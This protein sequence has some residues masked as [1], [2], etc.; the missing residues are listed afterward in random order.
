MTSARPH[1]PYALPLRPLRRAAAALWLAALAGLA[2]QPAWAE[3]PLV[4]LTPVEAVDGVLERV[5]FGRVVAKETVDLAFQVGGQILT[6]PVTE[7]GFA[8]AGALIAELDLEPF[9]LAL[10]EAKASKDQIDRR[11]A[12]LERLQGST[13]SQVTVDDAQ[14]EAELAAIAVRNAERSLGL[15]TLRAPFD[16]LVSS[17]MV[18]NFSTTEAGAPVVRLHDMSDLRIEIDVPEVLF[19]RAGR[20]PNVELFAEFPAGTRPYPLAPREFN[21]ETGQ[22]GQTFRIT[23]GMAPPED[24]VVLPGSSA[25]VRTIIRHGAPRIVVPAAAVVLAPDGTPS[26]M[27]FEPSEGDEN[28]GVVRRRAVTLTP[29]PAGEVE[30]ASG[31]A[32]GVEIVASGGGRLADGAA[33]R[34]FRGFGE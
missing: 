9:Q 22:V 23:L 26:V 34:R 5:F 17:R 30:V 19:Q 29:S 14:T 8:P 1:S 12:R 7:G 16:A 33:V 2:A 28:A 25:R 15:A 21:A 20:D 6:F 31:L 13:V 27:V 18:A 10:D 24:L 4:K 3:A 11:L 32:P